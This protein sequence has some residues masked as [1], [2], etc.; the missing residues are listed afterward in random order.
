MRIVQDVPTEL[1]QEPLSDLAAL[2]ALL[3]VSGTLACLTFNT[4]KMF[5]KMGMEDMNE[6]RAEIGA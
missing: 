6:V 3:D 2:V 5:L 4:R 1:R